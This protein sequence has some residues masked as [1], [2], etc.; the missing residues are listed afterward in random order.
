MRQRHLLAVALIAFTTAAGAQELT[1]RK[2]VEPIVK[3]YCADC[4]GADA[5]EY[6]EWMLLDEAKRRKDGPRMDTYTTFMNYVVWPATGAMMRRLDDGSSADGKPGNMYRY[7]GE[8]DQER[9]Q[10]LKT[11]KTWMGDG[12]W[13][14]NRFGARGNV[15]GVTKEQLEKVKAKY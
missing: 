14:L 7:L 4:H 3:K 15:P 13:F 6:G 10:N 1:W 12:A 2:D 5:R 9:A 8:T 11:I